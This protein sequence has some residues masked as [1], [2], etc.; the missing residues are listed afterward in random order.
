LEDIRTKLSG[1][2]PIQKA[3]LERN[4]QRI[5]STSFQIWGLPTGAR[6]TL[7]KLET[8]DYLM[9]LDTDADW[10]SFR[11]IGRVL[12]YLP[13]EHWELSLHLWKERKFPL[14]VLLRGQLIRYPWFRFLN[15]FKFGLGM[16]PMGRT[17]RISEKSFG[18]GPATND[19]VFF[20]YV[21]N[22]FP[23][24]TELVSP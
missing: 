14:I 12:Y 21:T 7:S 9:L 20:E 23:P 15:D 24:Y 10:G 6:Q 16:K 22:K 17:Y 1:L 2:S 4:F 3:D 18:E 5:G 11:Y 19:S 13:G 8:G